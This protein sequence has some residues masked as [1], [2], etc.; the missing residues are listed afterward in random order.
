MIKTKHVALAGL[1]VAVGIGMLAATTAKAGPEKIS[2]PERY[3]SQFVSLG[4]IDRYEN[5]TIRRI[6]INPEAFG[7]A[8]TGRPL[9]DGTY[10]ILEVRPAKLK[11]NGD[12][13]LDHEGRFIPTDAITGINVQQKK[14]GWGT[15][16]SPLIRNGEWE[17]AVFDIDGKPRANL[18]TTGC[19]TCHKPRE[20]EDF[21]FVVWR[22]LQ[23]VKKRS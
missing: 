3:Q 9:P 18:N 8:E 4:Q 5:K 6:F 1:A 19:L 12:P 2:Y 10:L 13:E 21:T 22:L 15:E 14:R 17:Y 23:D 7:A 16:Y 20:K 11:A